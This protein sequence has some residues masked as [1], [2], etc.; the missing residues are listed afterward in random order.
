MPLVNKCH[1]DGYHFSVANGRNSPLRKLQWCSNSLVRPN[2]FII[3]SI[4][5]TSSILGL[6]FVSLNVCINM[7][8]GQVVSVFKTSS[9][10]LRS[11]RFPPEIQGHS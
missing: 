10:S 8:P 5:E 11:R 9:S 7:V 3:Q 1:P 4:T 2:K 6:K